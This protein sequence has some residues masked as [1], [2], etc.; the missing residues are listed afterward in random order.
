MAILRA[1]EIRKMKTEELD[2]RMQDL[3]KELMKVKMQISQ[4]TVPEKPGRVREIRKTIARILTISG[5]RTASGHGTKGA[6]PAKQQK[7]G[8]IK[9]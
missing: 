5:Q 7:V 2:K 1:E 9:K 6:V 4:G 8:G 3:K